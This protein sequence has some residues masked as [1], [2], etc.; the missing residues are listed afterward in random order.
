MFKTFAIALAA[1]IVVAS[2]SF[3]N[4]PETQTRSVRVSDLDLASSEGRTQLQRRIRAAARSVCRD[5]A[6]IGLSS[7]I[8]ERQCTRAAID[9]TRTQVARLIAEAGSEVAMADI[10]PGQ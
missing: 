7:T 5:G 8:A 4:E 9:G 3:A 2:P 1:S 10:K 6:S